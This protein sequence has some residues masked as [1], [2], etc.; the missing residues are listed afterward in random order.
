LQFAVRYC[1]IMS[2]SSKKVTW[3][4]DEIAQL[5]TLVQHMEMTML[6][7]LQ[8][9]ERRL[10][11]KYMTRLNSFQVYTIF[12]VIHIH[13]AIFVYFLILIFNS[14]IQCINNER[15][16]ES[17]NALRSCE[18]KH[19]YESRPNRKITRPARIGN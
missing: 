15:E 8:N 11:A 6:Q 7:S 13:F 9:W 4:D 14:Q 17:I 19:Q 3:L 5:C 18:A 2:D 16:N 1:L 12:K 10:L